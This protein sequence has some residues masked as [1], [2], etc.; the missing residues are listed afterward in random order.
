MDKRG[1]EVRVRPQA[2]PASARHRVSD[3]G[4]IAD[5]VESMEKAVEEPFTGITAG[6]GVEPGLFALRPTGVSTSESMADA[7]AGFLAGLEPEQ[8]AAA[9]FAIDSD[10]W[11][12]WSN[13]AP[14]VMR[15][16]AG[17]DGLGAGQREGA[18]AILRESLSDRGYREARDVMR[19]NHTIGEITDRW[20]A[21]GEW[22]YWM[23]IF[24]VPDPHAP[25]GWQ[26]DGHHLNI[27]CLIVGDQIVTTPMFM[28]SEPVHVTTGKYA[29]TRVFEEE[30]RRGLA[31][32]RRLTPKQRARAVLSEELPREVFTIAFRDNFEMRYEGIPCTELDGN[33]QDLLL[34]L[35]GTYIGRTNPGHAELKLEE[36]RH[37][38]DRTYFA[39]MGGF[40]QGSV[41]YYR[42]HSPVVL[43]EFDHLAGLAMANDHPT[44]RHV[45]TIVRTPNGNDYGTDL[46][47]QHYEQADHHR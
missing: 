45:H 10:A 4:P 15:H 44:R 29:G 7:A 32:V 14:F 6:G 24:G 8:R 5:F 27:N 31:L 41:F 26:I 33:Q 3:W 34:Q 30:E 19:L 16:G 42:I 22:L 28:G 9:T 11:R 47:R 20:E 43:I 21:Y 23:S 17:L 35:L 40:E 18:L 12:R 37:H 13:I 2:F 46:L 39:W 36:I 38:L 25:W 1:D